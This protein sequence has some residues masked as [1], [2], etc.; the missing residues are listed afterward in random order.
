MNKFVRL[1]RFNLLNRR[2]PFDTYNNI[3]CKDLKIKGI[4]MAD[5]RP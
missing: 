2:Y 5:K 3:R 4:E 1:I